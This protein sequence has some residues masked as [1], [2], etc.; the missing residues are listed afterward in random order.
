MLNLKISVI[1]P[2]INNNDDIIQNIESVNSQTYKNF[3]HIIIDG[4]S[5]ISFQ[6]I[7][8]RFGHLKT[9]KRKKKGIYDALN[10]GVK[11]SSGSILLFLGGNDYLIDKNI[12]FKIATLF[13]KNNYDLIFGKSIY[14]YQN[15]IV[16][17]YSNSKFSKKTIEKGI[18]PAH[19]STFFKKSIFNDIG[20][21]DLSLKTASDF[22]FY[23]RIIRKSEKKNF[24]Y[25]NKNITSMKI[26]GQ[27]SKPYSF[28][29]N[30]I[31]KCKALKK[32]DYNFSYFEVLFYSLK[33]IIEFK[34]IIKL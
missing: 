29:F 7:L 27:S 34:P 14:K 3:E 1:T 28:I 33:K 10:F 20:L 5:D 30:F 15:K 9:F 12:F 13:E 23:A 21:Y 19:T 22:E 31:E 16:R 18:M 24:K 8:S 11:R 4:Y 2:T 25:L 17:I 32:N 26:F 6:K